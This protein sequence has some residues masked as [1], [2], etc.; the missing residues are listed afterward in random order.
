MKKFATLVGIAVVV[1]MTATGAEGKRRVMPWMCL[2]RCH[3]NI[4][5]DLAQLHQIKDLLT[6]VSFEAYDLDFGAVLK[7]NKFSRV[8]DEIHGMGL[9]GIAMITTANMDKIRELWQNTTYFIDQALV[10]IMRKGYDGYNI[11]FEPSSGPTPTPED[12]KLFAMFVD[13]FAK[14]LHALGRGFK[15]S[16]DV[17]GWSPLLDYDLLAATEVDKVM[18]MDTYCGNDDLFLQ[19]VDNAVEKIGLGK[20]GIGLETGNPNTGK[21]FTKEQMQLRFNKIKAVDTKEIDIWECPIPELWLPLI[22][23]FINY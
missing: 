11:D 2:E 5:R 9:E 6:A 18:T 8:F 17:A 1:A 3:E 13:E 4:T 7:D 19:R 14:R 23:D 16:V 10:E 22:K 15:L 20:L 12:A 21:P